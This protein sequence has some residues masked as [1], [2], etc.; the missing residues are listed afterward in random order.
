VEFELPHAGDRY[1]YAANPDNDNVAVIDSETLAIQTVEA[2]DGPTFLQTLGKKDA[3][4]VLNTGSDD[5]TIIRTAGGKSTT[6]TVDVQAG[7]NAIAVSSDGLRAVVYYDATLRNSGPPGSFQDISVLDLTEGKERSIG[8]TVGFRP[9]DVVFAADGKRAMVVTEGGVSILSF[10]DIEKRGA[11]IADT[12]SLGNEADARALDVSVTP[13]GRYALARR[14][15]DSQLRLADLET[16]EL[17]ALDL[18]TF[19]AP[20]LV[21]GDGGAP[22]PMDAP[23]TDLDL[24]PKGDFALAVVRGQSTVLNVPIPGAFDGSQTVTAI[25]LGDELVGSVTLSDDNKTALLYTTVV[26]DNERLTILE[27]ETKKS[28]SI[29]LPKA[30]AKVTI[31][32]DGTT[33][34]VVHQK[35]AGDPNQPGIDPDLLIDRSFGYSLVQLDTGFS[36]LQLT[37]SPL[38]PSIILPDGSL[39]F[40]LFNAPGLG[41]SEVHRIELGSFLVDPITLGSAPI[42]VGAVPR[43]KKVFVGQQHPDGRITFIDWNTQETESV[44]GFELNSKIRE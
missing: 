29:S 24:A 9:S 31:S 30:V 4:I 44:T 13:D 16:R 41:I 19:I 3:A 26:A 28:R 8:M 11:H 36:K 32:P 22:P 33:A 34:L 12:V 10:A 43:S 27:L 2:G 20:A 5:A 7:S 37:A 6:T 40:A 18:K 23:I 14:E 35:V 15:G 42:S 21:A 1:V 38:G 25:S 39:L 17:L